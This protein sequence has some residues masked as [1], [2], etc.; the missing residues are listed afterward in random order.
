VMVSAAPGEP[1]RMPFW[2]GDREPAAR[3]GLRIGQLT[4]ELARC[5]QPRRSSACSAVTTST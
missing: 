5:R 1:G 4:R 3:L 2:K